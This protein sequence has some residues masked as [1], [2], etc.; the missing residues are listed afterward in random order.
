MRIII[1]IA[2]NELKNLF[3]SPVAWFLA[4][5]MMVM[6]AFY[7]TGLMY[8]HAKSF[9]SEYRNNPNIIFWASES[10][11]ETIFSNLNGGFFSYLM[12]HLYLFI[13]LLTMGIISREFNSGSIRLLYSSP[14]KLRTIVLGKYLAITVYN[15]LLVMI[16]G[17][18]IVSGFFDIKNLDYPPLLSAMLGIYLFLCALAAIGFFMSSLTNYQIV[19][20]IAS[21]TLLFILNRI[22]GLWQEYDFVRDLTYFLSI[23]GRTEKMLL[24][25][26]RTK[27]V[28]YYLIIIYMFVGF[29]LLRLKAGRESKPRYIKAG[30][31][32]AVIA[33]GLLFGYICSL[34]RFTG[35]LDTTARKTN[36]IHPRT[37]QI[38][39]GL[40]EGPLEVTLYTNLFCD[41]AEQGFP[42]ERN[43]YLTELWENY[44]RFKTDIKFRYEY[45]YTLPR[46]D[47]SL[48]KKY[49]GKT[50]QQIAGLTARMLQVDSAVFKSPEQMHKIINLEPEDYW[51]IMQLKYK[52]RT[53]FLRMAFKDKKWPDE[54]NMNAALKRLLQAHI[55]KVYFVC[56]ELERNIYK[57]GEREY[58]SH[59]ID[60][61]KT[62][63][64]INVGFDI[65][66]LNLT[67]QNIPA[68]ASIVVLADPRT[69]LNTAVLNKL[70]DY[71]NSGG[72]ML[73]YGKP[74]KQY[75]L[76]PLLREINVQLK[77]G[78]L[79]Q[80]SVNETPDKTSI[81]FTE[82]ALSL[83]EEYWFMKFKYLWSKNVLEDS[84]KIPL[85]G[86][87]AIAYAT[88]SSFTVNTLFSTL[89]GSAWL[90]AGK[91]VV[92]STAPVFSPQEGDI[93]QASFPVAVQ[94][95][96]Q[97]NN[98]EQRIVISGDAD[99]ASN[100]RLVDDMARAL[101]SWLAYN[102]F[103]IYT[104]IPYAK[105]NIII[106]SP[107]RAATQKIIYLWVLPGLLLVTGTVLLIRRKRK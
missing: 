103:P 35:Y 4:I 81:Y 15:L 59:T 79:V 42:V 88:D 94:L 26:I 45:Y 66:T 10:V 52:N 38:I 87:A 17:I 1:K 7:Y 60:K 57:R 76:N 93:K 65:D 107:T 2:K 8:P 27:D 36:T 95:S 71:L 41:G 64:L 54:Q 80:P 47:S 69:D 21:F 82:S 16:V 32:I 97:I 92:D 3:Y 100:M 49:P 68:D 58:Y 70:K 85:A 23:A 46:Y 43:I 33:S 12:Q 22:G 24:G 89:P 20:A 53:T 11:T 6:C 18:F 55:P 50:L 101:Y 67:T 5:I 13:P 96:R 73:V 102:E 40:N 104:P 78:Q 63:S 83:A 14:V 61:R 77:D 56:G 28:M 74:G 86:A 19:S 98:K 90:K 9:D 31:Y 62:G 39:N 105:D 48:Y 75:V 91:L 25:L 84:V 72:N 44:Q 37:Q 51:M 106:L 29:T 99:F 30:R 34:P